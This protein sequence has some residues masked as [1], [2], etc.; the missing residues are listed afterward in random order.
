MFAAFLVLA[1][2]LDSG[3]AGAGCRLD[4]LVELPVTLV[5]GYATVPAR[6]GASP[7]TFLL[8]SA[9]PYSTLSADAVTRLKTSLKASPREISSID[10]NGRSV[11]LQVVTVKDLTLGRM[12]YTG[13]DF[14]VGGSDNGGVA[15]VLGQNVLQIG[16]VDYDLAHGQVSVLRAE[17]CASTS[18]AYW[19]TSQPYSVVDLESATN[20]AS[21]GHAMAYLNG[22]RVD[23]VLNTASPVSVVSPAV[24]QRLGAVPQGSAGADGA[25]FSSAAFQSFRIGDEEIKNVRLRVADANA[26]DGGTEL[27]LGTDFMRSH[28]VYVAA[29]QHKVYLTY[30]GGQVFDL[31]PP[32]GIAAAPGAIHAAS[33]AEPAD[34]GGYARRGSTRAAAQDYAGA[35]SDLNRAT[36]LAPREAGYFYQLA[37]VRLANGDVNQAALDLDQSVTLQPDYVPALLARA[38]LRLRNNQ[39]AQAAADVDAADASAPKDSGERRAMA[40]I[41]E[42]TMQLPKAILQNDLWIAAHPNDPSLADALR[43]RCAERSVLRE[44]LDRALED[45]DAA[46][47]LRG[48][49]AWILEWRATVHFQRA[50]YP[51][52]FSDFDAA[53][54]LDPARAMVQYGRGAA[55]V[56][57]KQ[58]KAG[59]ADMAA[60]ITR[61]PTVAAQ[62]KL[63][64]IEP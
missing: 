20:G 55:S 37:V 15:G 31:S 48:D 36:E 40:L 6:V 58:T 56:R 24:V 19:A 50:E 17:G 33:D 47:K 54:K 21:P 30:G 22:Q 25:K 44:H 41:Y 39:L 59:N 63:L 46:V 14:I 61:E 12:P 35:I 7:E 18:L 52:A 9:S 57:L 60:A 26:N 49:S 38:G 11:A 62:A 3:S 4:K 16:D 28:H 29:S 32:V 5:A 8:A 43:A 2:P 51:A 23:V 42:R 53:I 10:A 64:G 1:L 34:A 27:V 13:V 45:C